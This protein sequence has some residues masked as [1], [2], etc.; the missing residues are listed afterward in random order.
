ML[1]RD[2]EVLGRAEHVIAHLVSAPRKPRLIRAR[3]ARLPRLSHRLEPDQVRHAEC[4]FH[5]ILSRG[6]LRAQLYRSTLGGA[7]S[8]EA[9]E[10]DC[11][12]HRRGRRHGSGCRDPVRARRRQDRRG[13]S[14]RERRDGDGG[15]DREAGR[16]GDRDRCRHH[17]HGRREADCR[18]DRRRARSAECPLQQRRRRYRGQAPPDRHLR[19]GFRPHRRGQSQGP[20]AR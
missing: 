13:R 16:Q 20:L 8:H 11:D 3:D 12:H 6:Y 10:Q 17:A 2:D 19:G 14:H 7:N 4:E 1:V 15:R 5:R 18:A 9:R